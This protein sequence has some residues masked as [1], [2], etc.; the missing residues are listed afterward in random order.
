MVRSDP[1]SDQKSEKAS[2]G[3]LK[4]YIIIKNKKRLLKAYQIY[5][6]ALIRLKGRSFVV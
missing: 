3:L 1:N 4:P 5:T 6:E 2:E